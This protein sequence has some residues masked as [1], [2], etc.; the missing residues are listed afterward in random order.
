M[1]NLESL[2]SAVHTSVNT[3]AEALRSQN[4]AF[5]GEF[6]E[7]V[8]APAKPDSNN[9]LTTDEGGQR[10]FYRPKCVTMLY[11]S[12]TSEGLVTQQVDVPLLTLVPVSTSRINEVKFKTQLEINLDDTGLMQVSFPSKSGGGLFTSDKST[13][14]LAE[15][16]IIING[17]MPSEGLQS[18]IDGYQK[19]LRAQIPG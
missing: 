3:A 10:T 9:L 19:A 2:V 16:E 11:P 1:I 18:L 5:I 13:P 12:E 14:H 17:D 8:E 4:K 6:F 7:T 15:L